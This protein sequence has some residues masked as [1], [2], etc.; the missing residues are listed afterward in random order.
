[1]SPLLMDTGYETISPS[2]MSA[3]ENHSS[4]A[5]S[6]RDGEGEQVGTRGA[7]R[8][9]KNRNAARKS[10][11]KQTERADDLHEE[12]QNLERSNSA[13]QKEIA[14]LKKDLHFY[15]T[16]LERHQP[17]CTL[18]A[19]KSSSTTHL[20]VPPSAEC[21]TGSRPLQASSSTQAAAPSHS[22]PLT[23]TLECVDSSY[24]SSTIPP[25][26]ASSLDSSTV[27]S[28]Q[29]FTPSC[30]KTVPYSSPLSTVPSPL[31]LFC[32]TLP[33]L[34]TSR[35][36]KA[37]TICTS[38]ISS[39]VHSSSVTTPA[40]PKSRKRSIHAS[41][42]FSANACFSTKPPDASPMKQ[43]SFQSPSSDAVPTYSPFGLE[44][45]GQTSQGCPMNLSQ[46]QQGSGP[47]G[48]Q[49]LTGLPVLFPEG[50]RLS[51]SATQQTVRGGGL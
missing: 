46:L 29:F 13:F 44:N 28:A 36:T 50:N 39:P 15:T 32:E 16:A 45:T 34:I 1:M 11:K 49:P 42:S 37:S 17:H 31:S 20:S 18:K 40:Q 21:E 6:E 2:S 43:A 25:P 3:E 24:R 35:M 51:S 4:N 26:T 22:T 10:R 47:A 8:Q 5:G 23:S 14:S 41:S 30:S 48:T 12:L 7:K 27:S 38:L 33:S 19:S 9:E